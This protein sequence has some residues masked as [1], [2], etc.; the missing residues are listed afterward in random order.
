MTVAIIPLVLELKEEEAAGS[1][2]K[3]ARYTTEVQCPRSHT[4]TNTHTHTH[5]KPQHKNS[6]K[7]VWLEPLLVQYSLAHRSQVFLGLSCR[8]AAF[9]LNAS[10]CHLP[11]A[12]TVHIEKV[13]NALDM[14]RRARVDSK[15]GFADRVSGTV[16]FGR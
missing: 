8:K 16:F 10:A 7:S 6:A 5:K 2:H 13:I 11:V 1:R 4:H 3:I 15:M 12:I 14:W 9:L